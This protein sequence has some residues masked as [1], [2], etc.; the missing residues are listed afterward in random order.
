QATTEA[1]LGTNLDEKS[2]LDRITSQKVVDLS[3]LA[4]QVA[5]Q[6]ALR[7]VHDHILRLD[8]TKYSDVITKHVNAIIQRVDA[9]KNKKVD[10]IDSL[11]TQW[12]N[13]ARGSY[14]RAA[15]SLNIDIQNTDLNDLEMCRI[16]N[17]RIMKVKMMH[18]FLSPYVSLRD[19]PFRHIF[20]GS[21][22]QTTTD[23]EKYLGD[24]PESNAGFNIDQVLNDFALLTWTIQGCANDLAGDIWSLDNEI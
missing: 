1:Y 22:R 9:L 11:S 20:F 6:I 14:S 3:K 15:A 17:N 8:V 13:S 12:L 23:L 21:G 24:M 16:I 10:K 2:H 4:A 19:V 7:L 18:N 5:G